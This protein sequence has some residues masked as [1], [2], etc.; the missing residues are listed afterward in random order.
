MVLGWS[1][2]KVARCF[3][4][5]PMPKPPEAAGH[6]WLHI[7]VVLNLDFHHTGGFQWL[8]FWFPLKHTTRGYLPKKKT[9]GAESRHLTPHQA[10]K[11]HLPPG[12]ILLGSSPRISRG[13][14]K[15]SESSTRCCTQNW[16]MCLS[17]VSLG[18]IVDMDIVVMR[19]GGRKV[20]RYLDL[21]AC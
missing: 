1:W 21:P 13:N 17:W 16:H 18:R 3:T 11:L 14:G 20:S 8:S 5:C 12:H 15:F 9:C 6:L 10:T 4:K 19:G 7:L 2:G